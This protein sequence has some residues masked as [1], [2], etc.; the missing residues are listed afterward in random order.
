[1]NRICGLL[2]GC[3]FFVFLA[4]YAYAGLE[5]PAELQAEFPQYAD[6]K[7][8]QVT[9]VSGTAIVMMDC[10]S[11]DM[12]KVFN[13]YMSKAKEHGWTVQMENRQQEMMLLAAEKGNKKI[14]LTVAVEDGK[15]AVGMTL[16]TE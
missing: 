5:M 15:T 4:G 9:N 13:F 7:L 12:E 8:I 3:C 16:A 2:A 1:M 14:M 6:S 11:A 10:G